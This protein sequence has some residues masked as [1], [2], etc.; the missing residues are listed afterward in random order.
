MSKSVSDDMK[1]FLGEDLTTVATCWRITCTDGDKFYFTDHDVDI[2]I[3]EETYDA[4]TGMNPTTIA[5][6]NDLSVDNLEATAFLTSEKIREADL[7][8]GKFDF[9]IV[10]I[11]TVDFKEYEATQI[12]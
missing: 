9:A 1:E 11:F 2:I 12:T 3:D 8:A 10:D 7:M 5:Q 4:S 6:K